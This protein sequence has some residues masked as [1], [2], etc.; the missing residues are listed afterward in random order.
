MCRAETIQF[1][2]IHKSEEKL[3]CKRGIYCC[4]YALSIFQKKSKKMTGTGWPRSSPTITRQPSFP[5]NPSLTISRTINLYPL[6]NYTF[7]TKD[8]LFEKDPSVPAR[9][10]RMRDEYDKFGM[11]RSVDGVLIVHEHGLPH[12]LLLQ[13]ILIQIKSRSVSCCP[14]TLYLDWIG[15]EFLFFQL[16]STFF[17][18]PGGELN[19]GEDEVNFG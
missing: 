10:Q 16:G 2:N 3:N 18:L 4:L 5:K 7:G 14:R 15:F 1:T 17:K 12:V 19:P 8:P 13:V 9:F 6:S 11:R